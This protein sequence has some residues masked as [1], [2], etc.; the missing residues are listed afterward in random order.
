[1]GMVGAGG[2]TVRYLHATLER[3][4][5]LGQ[6]GGK[7]SLIEA[8]APDRHVLAELRIHGDPGLRSKGIALGACRDG[9]GLG[10]L[11][12]GHAHLHLPGAAGQRTVLY[13]RHRAL[14]RLTT[15]G[16]RGGEAEAL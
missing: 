7:G 1:M 3:G 9:N 15:Y 5:L 11:I 13:R 10:V 4:D 16:H 8:V 14:T 6:R 2:Y 12:P